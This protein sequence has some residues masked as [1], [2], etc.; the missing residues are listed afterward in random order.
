MYRNTVHNHELPDVCYPK[1]NHMFSLPL[2]LPFSFFSL[3]PFFP[4]LF[5]FLFFLFSSFPFLF[6]FLSSLFPLFFP[7]FLLFFAPS[8]FPLASEISPKIFQGWANRPLRPPLVTP[9]LVRFDFSYTWIQ[10]YRQTLQRQY[11]VSKQEWSLIKSKHAQN[12]FAWNYMIRFSF[13]SQGSLSFMK[14]MNTV[15]TFSLFLLQAQCRA[16]WLMVKNDYGTPSTLS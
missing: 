1:L 13:V 5:L 7:F 8:F 9:L 15:K 3:F 12:R 11:H 10:M 2:S 6:P 4:L 16:P 14:S